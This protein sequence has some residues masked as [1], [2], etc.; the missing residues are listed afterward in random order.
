M[1]E[2]GEPYVHEVSVVGPVYRGEATLKR[3]VDELVPL[4]DTTTTP[5]GNV[6]RVIE[7]LLVHD[8]RSEEHTSELQSR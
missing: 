7:V 3:L 1:Q 4:T 6:Y 2:A 5:A 8:N